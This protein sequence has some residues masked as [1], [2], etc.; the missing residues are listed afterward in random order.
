VRIALVVPGGV[1]ASGTERVIPAFVWLVERL[2]RRHDVRVFAMHQQPEPAEW[3]LLGARVE[4][5]GIGH[6]RRRRFLRR[7]AAA[8]QAAPFD[9]VHALFGTVGPLAMLAA[10]RHRLPFMMHLGGGELVAMHDIGYGMLTTRG[11]LLLRVAA[12]GAR[13]VTVAT[14]FMQRLVHAAGMRAEVVPLGVALDRWPPRVPPPR[15]PGRPARLLHIGD[16]R[17]VKDQ[18]MLL[19]AM[20]RLGEQG[21]D[22]QLDVAGLDTMAGALQR[23]D[24]AVRLGGRVKWHG[25]LSRAAL[26]A[27]VDEADLLVVTSRHEAGPLAVLEAAVAGVPAVGTAVG[28]VAD[29]APDAA[30]AVPVGDADALAAGIVSLLA[31]E[32]HRLALARAAQERAV[33]SDAD[34]TAG[35]FHLMYDEVCAHRRHVPAGNVLEVS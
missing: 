20:E 26:R 2:A 22:F 6:G 12:F 23:S 30:V 14:S 21:V 19:A 29:W 13:R 33:L 10:R 31:N 15:E 18:P 5:I 34:A 1:D 17:P 27:L 28:H 32:P 35:R 24:G 25:L 3:E 11:R 4:N 8:H 16:L 7:F 9:V